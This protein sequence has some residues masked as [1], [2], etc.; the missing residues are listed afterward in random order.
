M[1]T[2]QNCSR[3]HPARPG[4]GARG[5]RRAVRQMHEAGIGA[6][7]TQAIECRV[8]ALFLLVR[9]LTG[10]RVRKDFA[11]SEM[12]HDAAKAKVRTLRKLARKAV[13][14]ARRNSQAIQAPINFYI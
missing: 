12:S 5:D 8:K 13:P 4:F 9:L 2:V 3:T 11:G 1:V 14:V 7:R 10:G 6:E